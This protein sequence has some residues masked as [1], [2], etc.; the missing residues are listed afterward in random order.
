MNL[1]CYA[2]RQ[3][4]PLSS[5]LQVVAGDDARAFSANGVVWRVQTVAT[6]PDHTWRSHVDLAAP[7]QFFNWGWWSERDG[8][9]KVS[10]NPILDIGAMTAA[11]DQLIAALPVE[12][13]RV[14]FP[15]NDRFE[16]WGCE[17]H[18][19]PVAL[20][21][22]ALNESE[23]RATGVHAWRATEEQ[24]HGFVSASLA[25][26]SDTPATPQGVRT[27]A[28]FLEHQVRQRIEAY[29][30]FRREASGEGIRLDCSECLPPGSFPALGLTEKWDD[31]LTASVVADYHRW[32][33][34]LLLTLPNLDDRQRQRLEHDALKRATLVAD[35]HRVYPKIIDP[36][37]IKR[38]RIEARLRRSR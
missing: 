31:P 12:T 29:F 3:L 21:G 34:P 37:L 8:L 5:V 18:G 38:A 26:A 4:N 7:R 15:L 20:L 13:A 2:I 17:R 28:E 22:S 11:A 9:Q 10:A 33:A 36:S 1:A 23:I 6:R 32:C 16:L 35:L 19:N 27:D 30:W 25:K 14:P 24:E